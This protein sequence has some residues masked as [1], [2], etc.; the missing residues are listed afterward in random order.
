MLV[1]SEYLIN[2]ITQMLEG[3]AVAVQRYLQ[4]A[5]LA[6]APAAACFTMSR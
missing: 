3:R 6:H 4:P 5:W 1:S 2:T